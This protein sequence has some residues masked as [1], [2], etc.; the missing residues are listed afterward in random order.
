[1]SR[2]LLHATELV[3]VHPRTRD[4][5]RLSSRPPWSTEQLRGL[6]KA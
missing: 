2:P 5:V 3:F 4:A 1:V 6:R